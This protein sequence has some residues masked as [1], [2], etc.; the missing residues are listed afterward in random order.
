MG[1][2]RTERQSKDEFALFT[3]VVASVVSCSQT[4]SL[5]DLRPADLGWMTSPAV[6]VLPLADGKC[7]TCGLPWPRE[8]IPM[9]NLVFIYI[10]VSLFVSTPDPSYGLSF[11]GE[12]WLIQVLGHPLEGWPL[13]HKRWDKWWS[14]ATSCSSPLHMAQVRP[15]YICQDFEFQGKFGRDERN[16][17][18]SEVFNPIAVVPLRLLIHSCCLL[19]PHVRGS[20]HFQKPVLQLLVLYGPPNIVSIKLSLTADNFTNVCNNIFPKYSFLTISWPHWDWA[21]TTHSSNPY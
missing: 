20:H 17:K 18:S 15:A 1:P 9:I 16:Q 3:W 8:P 12:P 7:G 5:P 2:H 13:T 10:V 4:P 6:L 11:S 21:P 19:F 14:I